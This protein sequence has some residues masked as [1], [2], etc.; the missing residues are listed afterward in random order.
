MECDLCGDGR[1]TSASSS[2]ERAERPLPVSGERGLHAGQLVRALVAVNALPQPLNALEVQVG[3][4]LGVARAFHV[5]LLLRRPLSED[6]GGGRS[7]GGR[8]GGR[9]QL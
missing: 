3:D 5:D 9:L 6:H 1:D 4:E 7:R 2:W 8:P